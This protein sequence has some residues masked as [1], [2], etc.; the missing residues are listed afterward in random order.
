MIT[1]Y[2][3]KITVLALIKFIDKTYLQLCDSYSNYP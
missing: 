2:I 3:F 1:R